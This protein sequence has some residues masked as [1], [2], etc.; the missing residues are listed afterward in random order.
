VKRKFRGVFGHPVLEAGKKKLNESFQFSRKQFILIYRSPNLKQKL[1]KSFGLCEGG[2][3]FGMKL[4]K[5]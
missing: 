2:L 4:L 1:L 3:V 5:K